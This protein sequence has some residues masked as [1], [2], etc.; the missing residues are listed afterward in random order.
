MVDALSRIRKQVGGLFEED[1][2][3]RQIRKER[4]EFDEVDMHTF[5][6]N[7]SHISA[8]PIQLDK[9]Y[10]RQ[11]SE[12]YDSDIYFGP[13]WRI[14]NQYVQEHEQWV[15]EFLGR[16]NS[17]Y[18]LLNSKDY[19]LIFFKDSTWINDYVSAYH[20]DILRGYSA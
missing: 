6:S 17:P 3:A 20:T 10:K 2:V 1:R 8:S 13:I 11:L 4:E 18:K 19:S 14:L 7:E 5:N 15:P 9:E 12:S 16:L